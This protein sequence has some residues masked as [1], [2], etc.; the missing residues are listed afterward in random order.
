MGASVG[1]PVGAPVGAVVGA[2]VGA[3]VGATVGSQHSPSQAT[4]CDHVGF[5]FS[6][7]HT[8]AP[9][10]DFFCSPVG[11]VYG[12]WNLFVV[13]SSHVD[14]KFVQHF[15]ASHGPAPQLT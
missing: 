3:P 5:S 8:F 4:K 14:T 15:A 1:V 7:R 12:V 9:A 10:L 11:H 13:C 2:T 6:A